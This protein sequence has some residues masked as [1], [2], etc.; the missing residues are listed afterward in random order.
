MGDRIAPTITVS[1][2]SL[3][4]ISTHRNSRLDNLALMDIIAK[5]TTHENPRVVSYREIKAF[6]IDPKKGKRFQYSLD[7]ERIPNGR[8]L[9]Q[10]HPGLATAFSPI[11]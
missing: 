2:G 5:G 10:V 11:L 7:G 9:A 1:S 3:A 4:L 8:I 6:V